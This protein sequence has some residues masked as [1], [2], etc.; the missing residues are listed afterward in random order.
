MSLEEKTI[1][2]HLINKGIIMDL[3]VDDVVIPDGKK[4]R[5]E[6][7]VHPGASCVIAET[8]DGKFVL[9][10]QYRYP[11]HQVTIEIPAGKK[12]PNEDPIVTAKRELEAETGY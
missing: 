4:T 9:E 10:K 6:Y 5:R 11:I 12:E 7:T 3:Y 1:K 2:K 8:R